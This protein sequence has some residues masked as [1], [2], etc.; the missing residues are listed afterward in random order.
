MVI[1]PYVAKLQFKKIVS[2]KNSKYYPKMKLLYMSRYVDLL[3]TNFKNFEHFDLKTQKT[4]TFKSTVKVYK[5]DFTQF[6]FFILKY[7]H[8][9]QLFI[10]VIF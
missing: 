2:D 1:G 6:A 8:K 7:L 5:T 10:S 3:D 9:I 4:T